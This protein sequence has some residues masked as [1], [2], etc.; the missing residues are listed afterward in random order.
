MWENT[1]KHAQ[2]AQ[3]LDLHLVKGFSCVTC[4]LCSYQIC[5]QREKGMLLFSSPIR[6]KSL[7]SYIIFSTTLHVL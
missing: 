5:F 7:Y 2:Y 6:V 1:V 4:P 3:V